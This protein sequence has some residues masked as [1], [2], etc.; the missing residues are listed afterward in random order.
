MRGLARAQGVGTALA[1]SCR[2]PESSR[3]PFG[4]PDVPEPGG[5]DVH[6]FAIGKAL[7]ASPHDANAQVWGRE[8]AGEPASIEGEWSSR[9]N[10][11]ALGPDWEEGTAQVRQ[12]GARVYVLFDWDHGKQ[13]GM[14]D[15]ERE[16]QSQ[17]L[18]GRY[19]HLGDREIP[20]PWVGLIVDNRRIDGYWPQ[21]RLD[22]R[23]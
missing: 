2:M 8:T 18:V 10:G 9:W 14:I 5:H 6:E 4:V 20:R 21:G 16:A 3:N 13:R 17:R 12:I 23:R 7:A 15:A 19:I 22:F 11:G 1:V